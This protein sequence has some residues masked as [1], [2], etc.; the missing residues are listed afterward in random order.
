MRS[1]SLKHG[2][3]VSPSLSARDLQRTGL[4][5]NGHLYAFGRASVVRPKFCRFSGLMW[6]G[7]SWLCPEGAHAFQAAPAGWKAGLQAGLPAPQC[8]HN[9]RTEAALPRRVSRP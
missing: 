5:Y 6:G 3:A 8:G 9:R 1:G 4:G 7:Q 2:V